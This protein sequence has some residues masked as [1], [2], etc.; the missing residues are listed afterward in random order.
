MHWCRSCLA[1]APFWPAALAPF[2][3][4]AMQQEQEELSLEVRGAEQTQAAAATLGAALLE[5]VCAGPRGWASR[6]RLDHGADC[7]GLGSASGGALQGQLQAGLNQLPG[8]PSRLDLPTNWW[9]QLHLANGIE[10]TFGLW[11]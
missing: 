9:V 4:G 10:T 1:E 2:W 3:P 8:T 5:A 11:E 6:H 7:S